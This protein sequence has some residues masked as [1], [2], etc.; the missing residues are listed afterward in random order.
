MVW[1]EIFIILIFSLK[2]KFKDCVD[3][4][5]DDIIWVWYERD[6]GNM[7]VKMYG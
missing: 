6:C 5:I 2:I 7:K 3:F 4:L 1:I